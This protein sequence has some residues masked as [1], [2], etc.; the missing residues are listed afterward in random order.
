MITTHTIVLSV[1]TC[2]LLIPGIIF[3]QHSIS[4]LGPLDTAIDPSSYS[5]TDLDCSLGRR[6]PAVQY[7]DGSPYEPGF[8]FP[9][10]FLVFAPWESSC[11]CNAGY[12]FHAIHL[13]FVCTDSTGCNG[14]F[15][16]NLVAT[17]RRD[18]PICFQWWP[19]SPEAPGMQVQGSVPGSGYYEMTVPTEGWG[20]AYPDYQYGFTFGTLFQ[21]P[22][23]LFGL[24]AIPGAEVG[25]GRWWTI[26]ERIMYSLSELP[27]SLVAWADVVCCEIPVADEA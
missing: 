15:T 24:D 8:G 16:V 12:F 23:I 4:Y 6:T 9:G 14:D 22:E 26:G 18:A 1:T 21:Q 5:P 11:A 27:G 25:D 13:I 2:V 3:A 20:C 17:C 7:S 19:W 10:H